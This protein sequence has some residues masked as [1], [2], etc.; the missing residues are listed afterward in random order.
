[1]DAIKLLSLH[2]HKHYPQSDTALGLQQNKYGYQIAA[3]KLKPVER[4]LL[5]C[6]IRYYPVLHTASLL[7]Q[8]SNRLEQ[9]FTTRLAA[10]ATTTAAVAAATKER[11]Q[12]IDRP[13]IKCSYRG[14][15]SAFC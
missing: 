12:Q 13:V 1:M 4:Q 5:M 10:A 7:R 9:H 15:T 2:K 8:N 3:K 6:V 11:A 14:C